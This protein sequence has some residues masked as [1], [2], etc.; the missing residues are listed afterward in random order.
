MFNEIDIKQITEHGITPE[1][2]EEQLQR[3]RE[4]FP[5]LKISRSAVVGDGILRLTDSETTSWS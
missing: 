5:Y 4:K 1:R 3:F 2:I